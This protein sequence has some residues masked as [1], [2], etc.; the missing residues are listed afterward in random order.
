MQEGYAH[1]RG[2]SCERIDAGDSGY[3][4]TGHSCG[5]H[6]GMSGVHQP[7]L[8]ATYCQNGRTVYNK[9]NNRNIRWVLL[10]RF[11]PAEGGQENRHFQQSSQRAMDLLMN[12]MEWSRSQTGRMEFNPELMEFGKLINDAAELLIDSAHRKSISLN[13]KTPQ[14]IHVL[15]DKDMMST[16]LRNLITNAIKFTKK[17][18]EIVIAAE[19]KQNELIVTVKDTGIGIR[20]DDIDK[21]FRI[22]ETYSTAGT[23][24]EKGTGLGL[25]LCKEFVEKHGGKIWVESE[26]G[27]GSTFYFTIP[28][29]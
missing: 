1:T 10:W 26:V 25:I 29:V 24:N 12:L 7:G 2:F 11:T 27:Q 13:L 28:S 9:L 16:V 20:K 22:D 23:Q 17:G 15:A 3:G 5:F 6:K 8:L 18:G 19:K 4:H 14:N 21:L